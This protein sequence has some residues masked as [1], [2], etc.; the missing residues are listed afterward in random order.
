MKKLGKKIIAGFL[1]IFMG[2]FSP[3]LMQN[4]AMATSVVNSNVKSGYKLSINT[5]HNIYK[6]DKNRIYK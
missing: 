3:C 1:I 4:K 2:G 6:T 5:I